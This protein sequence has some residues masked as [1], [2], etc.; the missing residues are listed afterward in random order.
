M[1]SE[2]KINKL[3]DKYFKDHLKLFNY[4]SEKLS[5]DSKNLFIKVLEFCQSQNADFPN[6]D[7]AASNNPDNEYDVNFLFTLCDEALIINK[8]SMEIS[9]YSHEA[10]SLFHQTYIGLYISDFSLNDFHDSISNQSIVQKY[11]QR[12]LGFNEW[13]SEEDLRQ[14]ANRC[15][16]SNFIITNCNFTDTDEAV[17]N[18]GT[19]LHFKREDLQKDPKNKQVSIPILLEAGTLLLDTKVSAQH[20]GSHWVGCVLDI[21]FDHKEADLY[22]M[23][24]LDDYHWEFIANTLAR[25]IQFH[26]CETNKYCGQK[27]YNAFDGFNVNI[28][29]LDCLKQ[30]NEWACGYYAFK[31]ICELLPPTD[32]PFLKQ[33][34]QLDYELNYN[35][36]NY[37]AS[38]LRNLVYQA[39]L[40]DIARQ[41]QLTLQNHKNAYYNNFFKTPIMNNNND[42]ANWKEVQTHC[43]STLTQFFNDATMAYK[44]ISSELISKINN[45]PKNFTAAQKIECLMGYLNL[46]E[47]NDTRFMG[48]NHNHSLWQS[49]INEFQLLVKI[50]KNDI[51]RFIQTGS[52][53]AKHTLLMS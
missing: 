34:K 9:S 46:Q 35:N 44:G 30:P 22:Y 24:S 2:S 8:S 16:L 25:A 52:L 39:L 40:N 31:N 14:L 41:D 43:L 3:I 53:E 33:I 32:N 1:I 18:L 28:R 5:S 17:N 20:Q 21:D 4:T 42:E 51:N 23:N 15:G 27:E 12:N 10:A 19:L 6:L 26:I 49:S 45:I 50:I 11:N 29:F 7:L 36:P 48:S 37:F 47:V 13:L 38:R